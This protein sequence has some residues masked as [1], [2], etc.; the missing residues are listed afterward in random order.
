[1]V[2]CIQCFSRISYALRGKT[3]DSLEQESYEMAPEYVLADN[4]NHKFMPNC[5]TGS[6]RKHDTIVNSRYS[7]MPNI[8]FVVW[9]AIFSL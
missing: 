6:P 7:N 3:S 9:L 8:F 5:K 4:F 2:Q 1:M